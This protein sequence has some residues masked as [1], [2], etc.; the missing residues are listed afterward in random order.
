MSAFT[1]FRLESD[2]TIRIEQVADKQTARKVLEAGEYED[3]PD[4]SFKIS[5]PAGLTRTRNVYLDI[6]RSFLCLRVLDMPFS[7]PDKIRNIIPVK[8]EGLFRKQVQDLCLDYLFLPDEEGKKK[9]L[10]CAVGQAKVAALISAF[11]AEGFEPRV[12]AST[13]LI[14]YAG[15]QSLSL[16]GL[17]NPPRLDENERISLICKE[18]RRPSL[19]FRQGELSYTAHHREAVKLLRLTVPLLVILVALFVANWGV[20]YKDMSK[21]LNRYKDYEAEIFK[22]VF[23]ADAKLVDPSY[24]I[25]AKIHEIKENMAV[26]SSADLLDV[27][28]ILAETKGAIGNVILDE[29]KITEDSVVVKGTGPS[30]ESMNL[31]VEA[32]RFYYSGV[33]VS[34]SKTSVTGGV[35]FSLV[36]SGRKG[37]QS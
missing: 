37:L 10:L 33:K 19:N 34:D 3:L 6:P 1:L 16:E 18:L 36:L 12:I 25:K 20:R 21:R 9:M 26:L 23:P 22:Q 24:Q 27:F 5:L 8:A 14:S 28:E 30:F 31:M 2:K 17:L 11:Q 13:D 7:D 4:G 32:L 35:R 15:R 29:I